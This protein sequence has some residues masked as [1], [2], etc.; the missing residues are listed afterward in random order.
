M[1]LSTQITLAISTFSIFSSY[2]VESGFLNGFY[3]C[4]ETPAQY[5]HNEN[6]SL[7][8]TYLLLR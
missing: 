2:S 7:S 8:L 3:F 5:T 6:G 4:R 1:I